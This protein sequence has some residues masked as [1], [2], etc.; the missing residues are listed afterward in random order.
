MIDNTLPAPAGKFSDYDLPAK[1][2]DFRTDLAFGKKGEALVDSFLTAMEAG[3]F[4]VKT[5]R[6]RNGK[7]VLEMEHNPRRAK[8]EN[9]KPIWKPSG[10]SVTKAAWWVYVLTLDGNEGAFHIIS[11]DRIKRYLKI[12]K[13]IYKKSKM[14]NFAWSSTN[15]S[16]GHLL[17]PEAILDLMT[18]EAYDEV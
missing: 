8:D 6:Y 16:R 5:D 18:N 14:M 17:L 15:P 3:S 7:M 4:E 11:V 12:N 1:K 9:G 2:F 10:L 13:D